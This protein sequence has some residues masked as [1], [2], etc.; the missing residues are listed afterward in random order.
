MLTDE[1][2]KSIGCI[3]YG[4]A[5]KR[6]NKA[7]RAEVF[8]TEDEARAHGGDVRPFGNGFIAMR[9]GAKKL[10]E[11]FAYAGAFVLEHSRIALH[12]MVTAV[13]GSGVPCVAVRTDCVYVPLADGD[14]AKQ[15]LRN[16]KF[17]FQEDVAAG[18]TLWERKVGVL[19][20]E[21]KAGAFL[22]KAVIQLDVGKGREPIPVRAAP[23]CQRAVL[24]SETRRGWDNAELDAQ[25]P[26]STVGHSDE[27][28]SA[29]IDELFEGSASPYEDDRREERDNVPVAFEARVPGAG[30]TFAVKEYARRHGLVAAMLIVCPWNRL[31]CEMGRDGFRSATLHKLLGR[32]PD[33]DDDAKKKPMDLKGIHHIHFEEPYLYTV[34][35]LEWIARFM[36]KHPDIA[37]TMAGDP[38]QLRP[39]KQFL[40]ASINPDEYYEAIFAELFP[41][42]LTLQYSKRCGDESEGRRMEAMCEDLRTDLGTRPAAI[43][44][45]HGLRVVN[46]NDLTEED[47]RCP[48]IAA[49]RETVA[50]VNAWAHPIHEPE[51]PNEYLPGQQLLG[52][53]GGAVKGG[54]LNPN[55]LYTVG[56]VGV[57]LT[58]TNVDGK[59]F[60]PTMAQAAKFLRRPYC[61]TNHAVQGL[62]LGNRIFIHEVDHHMA[63]HRW[64]R[65]A[66]SRCSTLDIILVRH[67]ARARTPFDIN[68]RLASHYRADMNH[69]FAVS[70]R[71]YV[72]SEWVRTQL[73]RQGCACAQCGEDLGDS[74]SGWWSIDRISNQ[75][76][77]TEANCRLV[78]HVKVSPQCQ[79]ATAKMRD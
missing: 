37:Y 48:H 13:Q 46:F 36:R 53:G 11:G 19:R 68:N 67:P 51:R 58:V 34:R 25:L 77:H 75:M 47:A 1:D 55:E 22:P 8:S 16:A 12:R 50:K 44:A 30:K 60:S 5:G 72:S 26:S 9:S 31:K 20:C 45:R 29:F 56:E 10:R 43:L 38:G 6:T 28:M 39:V 73:E 32:C 23:V 54:R 7:Q 59:E 40:A 78:C 41:R 63:D 2:R 70:V 3:T 52:N 24:P 18:A 74:S 17:T 71:D 4:Q 35:E 79:A 49:T 14:K 64:V 76:G 57:R 65:T 33:G 69:G 62:S 61:T 27:E 42:R 66:V 21:V 15:A